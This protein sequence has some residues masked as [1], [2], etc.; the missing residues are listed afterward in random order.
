MCLTACEGVVHGSAPHP[1]EDENGLWWPCT[2]AIKVVVRFGTFESVREFDSRAYGGTPHCCFEHAEQTLYV[3][4]PP[5][6]GA[7]EP[8]HEANLSALLRD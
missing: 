1:R 2:G 5:R 8:D 6:T 7:E 4:M 3:S